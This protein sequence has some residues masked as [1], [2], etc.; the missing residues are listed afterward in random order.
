MSDENGNDEEALAEIGA[1][2]EE[3][4]TSRVEHLIQSVM[5]PD[6]QVGRNGETLMASPK[7]KLLPAHSLAFEP[8]RMLVWH[9][10][11]DRVRRVEIMESL[12]CPCCSFQLRPSAYSEDSNQLSLICP[13]CCRDIVRFEFED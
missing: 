4:N 8:R 2:L 12:K 5:G 6:Y 1:F 7:L 10:G 9:G 3:L 11:G 13:N